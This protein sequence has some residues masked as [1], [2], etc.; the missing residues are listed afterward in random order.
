MFQPQ[1]E[2][3]QRNSCSFGHILISMSDLFNWSWNWWHLCTGVRRKSQ[4]A[5]ECP[6]LVQQNGRWSPTEIASACRPSGEAEPSPPRSSSSAA[7]PRC[8]SSCLGGRRTGGSCQQPHMSDQSLPHTRTARCRWDSALAS[9]GAAGEATCARPRGTNAEAL[10][11]EGEEAT[12]RWRPQQVGWCLQRR[13]ISTA[14]PAKKITA[15]M[16]VQIII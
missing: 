12:W 16:N 14:S 6:L 10:V 15:I 7:G 9:A 13:G 8:R 5:R 11:Q 2:L 4:S 1:F 3:E